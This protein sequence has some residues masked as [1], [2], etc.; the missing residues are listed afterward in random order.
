MKYGISGW[1]CSY[2]MTS[3]VS[4]NSISVEFKQGLWPFRK[5]ARLALEVL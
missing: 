2:L 4:L 3:A 5:L 1:G